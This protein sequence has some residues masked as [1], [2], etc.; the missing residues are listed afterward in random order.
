MGI[1][2]RDEIIDQSGQGRP[3]AIRYLVAERFIKRLGVHEIRI[4]QCREQHSAHES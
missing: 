1:K 4:R 3:V 2:A